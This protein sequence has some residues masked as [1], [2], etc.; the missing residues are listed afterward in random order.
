MV[1]VFYV[2]LSHGDTEYSG[3]PGGGIRK[4]YAEVSNS[5]K[6]K[7]AYP[8][9]EEGVRLLGYDPSLLEKL[10]GEVLESF[11]GVGNPF[12]LGPISP[13]A[14]VL[15]V[16]CGAGFDMIV[17]ARHVGPTGRVC[18]IDLTG[19]MVERSRKNVGLAGLFNREILEAGTEAIP[20]DDGSFDLVISNGVLNLSPCKEESFREIFRVL[21]KGGGLQFADIVLME[22]T[23]QATACSI[24]AWS[25]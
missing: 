8:T 19:E 14:A 11:C 25:D 21:K 12:E 3:D 7:F 22:G 23:A 6:G 24:D 2:S 18:G 15:D 10:P 20:F 4:K 13:G 9:G 1:S 16:G 17:A 5:A